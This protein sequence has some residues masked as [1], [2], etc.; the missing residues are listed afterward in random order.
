M[1]LIFRCV[2]WIVLLI[3]VPLAI[4]D[5]AAPV[6]TT[7]CLAESSGAQD[8]GRALVTLTGS[9]E[10]LACASVVLDKAM[11]SEDAQ[12]ARRRP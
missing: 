12:R 8:Q 6:V 2:L 5:A 4:W 10:A 1:L 3:N 7:I 9:E 11:L